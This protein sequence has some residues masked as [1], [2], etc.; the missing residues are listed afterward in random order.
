LPARNDQ[1]VLAF[2][3]AF[4]CLEFSVDLAADGSAC[5]SG[6]RRAAR[7]EIKVE[8]SLEAKFGSAPTVGS[9]VS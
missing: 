6:K 2:E 5:A 4:K 1:H 3:L 9:A 8:E 7:V